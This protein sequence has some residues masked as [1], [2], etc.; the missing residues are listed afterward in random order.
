M[1]D[2]ASRSQDCTCWKRDEPRSCGVSTVTVLPRAQR[3]VL[4]VT[5]RDAGS[6][7]AAAS[8]SAR[9]P[10]ALMTQPARQVQAPRM[11]P[12]E[13]QSR[14]RGAAFC[15]PLHTADPLS[16]T[17]LAHLIIDE[18][19]GHVGARRRARRFAP[20]AAV[21][22]SIFARGVALAAEIVSARVAMR[23]PGGA[24]G[25]SDEGREPAWSSCS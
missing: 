22:A 24:V 18:R 1:S 19:R 10:L 11:R 7:P 12:G 21:S 15:L 23:L 13:K 8:R 3:R 14:G 16:C 5:V 25:A 20:A 17:E 9:G 4:L 2:T 6:A